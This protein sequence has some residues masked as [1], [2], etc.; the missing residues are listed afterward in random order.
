MRVV[1]GHGCCSLVAT[2]FPAPPSIPVPVHIPTTS[3]TNTTHTGALIVARVVSGI[4]EASFQCI[5]PCFIDDSAHP[6]VKG[7]VLAAFFMANP[8]GQVLQPR[9]PRAQGSTFSRACAH[10]LSLRPRALSF[11][12]PRQ[13]ARSRAR[14]MAC[15]CAYSL[16]HT[17]K[18]M[19]HAFLHAYIHACMHAYTHTYTRTYTHTCIHAYT[20]TGKRF[21]I[22]RIQVLSAISCTCTLCKHVH[23]YAYAQQIC[24]NRILTHKNQTQTHVKRQ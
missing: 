21:W 20:S 17:H 6:S 14:N 5:A 22:R 13:R 2:R 7:K 3:H 15:I 16:I 18:H 1:S 4:G 23:T 24:T 19:M 12:R 10:S 8:I 9:P 11:M